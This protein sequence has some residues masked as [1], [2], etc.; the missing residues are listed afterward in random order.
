[1]VLVTV[2]LECNFCCKLELCGAPGKF[3]YFGEEVLSRGQVCLPSDYHFLLLLLLCGR[4]PTRYLAYLQR[5]CGRNYDYIL[6]I[7][8]L[9]R[10]LDFS[11][12][13]FN[14]H[15]FNSYLATVNSNPT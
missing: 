13:N 6:L 10:E 5:D 8:I 15:L 11:V 3:E 14:S 4:F 1:M 12:I 7:G 9:H 2:T